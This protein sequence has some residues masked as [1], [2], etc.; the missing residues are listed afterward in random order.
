VRLLQ[1]MTEKQVTAAKGKLTIKKW[2]DSKKINV[3]TKVDMVYKM[4]VSDF[5][6]YRSVGIDITEL[7][8]FAWWCTLFELYVTSYRSAL[9]DKECKHLF[10]FVTKS[11]K[12][13]SGSYWSDYISSLLFEH[14]GVSAA[15]NLLRSSF[16]SSFYD[17]AASNDPKLAESVAAVLRHSSKEAKKTYDRRTA[18]QRKRPGLDLIAKMSSTPKMTSKKRLS[19]GGGIDIDDMEETPILQDFEPA[20][21]TRK[22]E[23]AAAGLS[24]SPPPPL[25]VEFDHYPHAVMRTEG[26][27]YLLAPMQRSS[28]TNAPV[29]FVAPTA[30]FF[31]APLTSCKNAMRGKWV[32]REF[33][34]D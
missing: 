11:G 21:K 6:N 25:V 27:Q 12:P 18:T 17:S 33:T 7:D 19:F 31:P 20:T 28:F 34:L 1:F 2:V 32:G 5:K 22:T 4:F 9:V 26:S 15:T 10:V 8:S 16:V 13:F 30:H 14:T 3:I 29:Y 24:N 23:A